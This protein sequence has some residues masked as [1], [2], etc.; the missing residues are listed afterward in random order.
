MT[1]IVH[2][3]YGYSS[4]G[5]VR[6]IGN[7]ALR[8]YPNY[9]F[10]VL[11]TL[12]LIAIFGAPMVERFHGAMTMPSTIDDWAEN[13]SMIFPAIV[14]REVMP[15]LVPLAWALTVEIAY[16]ILIGLGISRSRR[17]T[18]LWLVAS[19]VYVVIAQFWRHPRDA[20]DEIIP[21]YLYSAIPAGSLPFSVG[22]LAWH[23]RDTIASTLGRLRIGDPGVL[24]VARWALYLGIAVANA[25]T[26]WTPIV[27]IGNWLNVALSGLIVCALFHARPA[28]RLR[29]I[30]KAVGDFSYPIYLLHLQMG[31]VAALI[32]FGHPVTGR[33][34]ASLAVFALTLVLTVMV[35]AVCAQLIDPAAERLR[36]RIKRSAA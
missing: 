2:G 4:G 30:D 34:F 22:A 27:M 17:S 13:L 5:F 12:A 19:L 35:G 11:V 33:S 3:T 24:I 28:P 16:Y 8:L 20:V 15:R 36:T 23:Y 14:P 18:W 21:I 6:Y 29:T 26:G 7:R 32:L 9:W 1:A 31:L 25:R 10:A